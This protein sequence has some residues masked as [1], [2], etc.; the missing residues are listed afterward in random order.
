M[1]KFDAHRNLNSMV[2]DV[3]QWAIEKGWWDPGKSFGEQCALFHSEISEALE[4][5]R[6]GHDY[7]EIYYGPDGKPEGVPVELADEIVRIMDT[8][9]HYGIDLEYAIAVKMDFN[10][11]RP[12]RHGGKA[13]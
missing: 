8:A 4:E 11:G 5:H 13:L 9:G 10:A 12:H 1:T 7:T 2:T 6:H 3:N